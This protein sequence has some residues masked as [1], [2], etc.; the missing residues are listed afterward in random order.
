M[1]P[2]FRVM[3]PNVRPTWC[4]LFFAAMLCSSAL[5]Q[6]GQTPVAQN[7][8]PAAA[9]PP[10]A[11]S[12]PAAAMRDSIAKQRAAMDVQREA[13]RKQSEAM[14]LE[15]LVHTV[16]PSAAPAEFECDPGPEADVKPLIE[17]AAKSNNLQPDLLRAV[18]RQ[19]SQFH[20]CAV[21]DKGA[22]GLMQLM[23]S[24]AQEFSVHDPFDPK[25]SI[26]G[27]AKYLKQ[28]FDKYKGKLDLVL[29]AYNAGP[30]AVDEA[31]GVPDI[32]E[33]RNYVQTIL[34]SL[35]EQPSQ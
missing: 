34:N 14:R 11:P 5:A 12:G 24:T 2:I 27:G 28:L 35:G 13:T 8:Q 16:Q 4:V 20:P 3:T 19:E 33:T 9:P 29:G 26:E 31:K 18:I 25:Q 6:S 23:P 21:S 30:A 1:P 10:A 7:G 17:S 15:P 32:P 22:E